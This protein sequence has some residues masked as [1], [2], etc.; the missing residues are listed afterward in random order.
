MANEI[1]L[2]INL[3]YAKSGTSTSMSVADLKIDVTGQRFV[4]NR[5]SIGT[6]ATALDLGDIATGGWFIGINRDAT[7]FMEIRSG[8]TATDIIR[9]NAGEPCCFRISADATA[10]SAIASTSAV[11]F[12]YILIAN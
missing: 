9:L 10:P 7:N 8:A 3:A 12:E 2:T 11:D 6:T 5:Q 1:T 4:H